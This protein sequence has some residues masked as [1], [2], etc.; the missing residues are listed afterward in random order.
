MR[1]EIIRTTDI[2]P[3]QPTEYV[4]DKLREWAD[5]EQMMQL[6]IE[7]PLERDVY[8][9][10]RFYEVW[11]LGNE[12]NF[13]FDLDR[14]AVTLQSQDLGSISGSGQVISVR[15]EIDQIADEFAAQREGDDRALIEEARAMVLGKLG[16]EE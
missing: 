16:R 1:R 2:D 12:I 7:G 6:R 9:R 8:H 10:L 15:H 14:A 3:A 5:A 11:R 4:Y 13:Y